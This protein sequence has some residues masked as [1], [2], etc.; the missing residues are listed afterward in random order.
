MLE[1]A[2]FIA[3][4]FV[5]D[6][7]IPICDFKIFDKNPLRP[8]ERFK[9]CIRHIVAIQMSHK[10]TKT[11]FQKLMDEVHQKANADNKKD[12][13]LANMKKRY[14][15]MYKGQ[16]VISRKKTGASSMNPS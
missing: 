14:K 2:I 12:K 5:E 7:G 15:S 10:H 9:R 13:M 11:R 3:E 1:E 16:Q 6:Y 4:E 8:I